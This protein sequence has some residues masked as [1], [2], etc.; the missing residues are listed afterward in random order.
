[1]EM[2]KKVLKM[3]AKTAA[4]YNADVLQLL[5]PKQKPVPR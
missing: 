2:F 5:K 3:D 1:M 4:S